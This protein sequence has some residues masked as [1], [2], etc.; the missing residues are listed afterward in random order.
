MQSLRQEQG[1]VL[2][3]AGL[4]ELEEVEGLAGVE[5][6]LATSVH[7]HPARCDLQTQTTMAGE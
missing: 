2:G 1:Q 5:L 7:D 3:E 4:V 6:P